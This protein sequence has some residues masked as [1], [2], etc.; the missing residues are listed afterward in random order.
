MLSFNEICDISFFVNTSH[1]KSTAWPP[2]ILL[3]Y[4]SEVKFLGRICHQ[5]LDIEVAEDTRN[6]ERG[7]GKVVEVFKEIVVEDKMGHITYTVRVLVGQ[8][9]YHRVRRGLR[10]GLHGLQYILL[11]TLAQVKIVRKVESIFFYKVN[12]HVDKW[13]CLS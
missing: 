1:N 4:Q 10:I 6:L 2:A 3:G 12:Y 8:I 9:S 7:I 13:L 5:R 11:D